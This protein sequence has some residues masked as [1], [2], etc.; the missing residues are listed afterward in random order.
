MPARS[1]KQYRLMAAVAHG[2]KPYG[3][4][5]PSQAVAQ[6]MVQATPANKRSRFMQA[7]KRK[8]KK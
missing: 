5:G 3:G 1:G 2:A 4:V 7:L 6:E 8:K